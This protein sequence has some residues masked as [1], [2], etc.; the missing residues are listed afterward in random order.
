MNE[1]LSEGMQF[2]KIC[3]NILKHYSKLVNS[4]FN[5]QDYGVDAIIENQANRKAIVEI[6]YYRKESIPF[7][8]IKQALYKLQQSSYKLEAFNLVLIVSIKIDQNYKNEVRE[9]FKINIL[10][11]ENLLYLA[12]NVPEEL[13]ALSNLQSK[14]DIV[15]QN[16]EYSWKVVPFDFQ[17]LFSEAFRIVPIPNVSIDKGELLFQQ[18]SRIEPGI[19]DFKNYENKCFEILKYLFGDFLEGWRKQNITEDGINI[20]DLICRIVY[21]DGI[22]SSFINDFK[23]RYLLFEFK[24]YSDS[25]TQGQVYTTE[26]YLFSKALR[27]VAIII[28]RKGPSKNAQEVTNGVLRE[29]GKLILHVDDFGLKKMLEIKDSGSDPSDYLFKL[30]DNMLLTLSK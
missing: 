28:S 24:N 8:F 20:F 27:N 7:S 12:A 15:R 10:D 6:K 18:L 16:G 9:K 5:A 3:I 26:K 30:L 29:S 19:S 23:S 2:E 14:S 25:I 21:N 4:N 17:D 22:W 13:F 11:I 1:L